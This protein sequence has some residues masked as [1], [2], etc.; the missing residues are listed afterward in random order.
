MSCD[1]VS[2]D[3]MNLN[4]GHGDESKYDMWLAYIG[5]EDESNYDVLV[6]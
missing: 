5:H 3:M 6:S 4:I 2:T 1:T